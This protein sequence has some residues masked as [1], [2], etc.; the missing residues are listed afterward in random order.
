MQTCWN[1]YRFD[2]VRYLEM[3]PHLR[4]ACLPD[5]F[6][7]F[8]PGPEGEALAV[9]VDEERLALE[10]ARNA[11][12]QWLCCGADPLPIDMGFP[13]FLTLM[14]RRR[15][16]Y[17]AGELLSELVSGG[18]GTES[19]LHDPG[20]ITGFLTPEETQVLYVATCILLGK[21][22]KS[23]RT[24]T[25]QRKNSPRTRPRNGLIGMFARFLRNIFLSTPR[26][27]DLLFLLEAYLKSAVVNGQG[28]AV[29]R[30]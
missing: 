3:R 8:L 15:G 20:G 29:S 11:V 19:W 18:R 23:G 10:A 24:S 14:A 22:G 30:I 9:A 4:P 28:L 26:H 1:L 13:R 5:E 21:G 7:A 17:E 16:G 12:V 2:Y 27:E 6:L 25:R